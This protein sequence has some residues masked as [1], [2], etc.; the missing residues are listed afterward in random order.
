MMEKPRPGFTFE[1][2]L[3]ELKKVTIESE[4]GIFTVT[5]LC[6]RLGYPYRSSAIGTWMR[7]W[8]KEGKVEFAGRVKRLGIDGIMRPIPAYRWIGDKEK[9]GGEEE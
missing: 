6:E 4:E 9:K 1:E 8:V 3:E 5:D 7:R 2:V